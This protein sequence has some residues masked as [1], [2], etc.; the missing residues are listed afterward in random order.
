MKKSVLLLGLLLVLCS[1]Q[2]QAPRPTG[3]PLETLAQPQSQSS[4]PPPQPVL[5]PTP[6]KTAVTLAWEGQTLSGVY[7]AQGKDYLD[8]G[9]LLEA[10]GQEYLMLPGLSEHALQTGTQTYSTRQGGLFDGQRFFWPVEELSGIGVRSYR[11]DGELLVL[12]PS[13]CVPSPGVEVPVLMY[14]S[15]SDDCWGIRE[16]FVSPKEMEKQLAYMAQQGY[17]GLWFSQLDRA[18]EMEKPVILTFDDGYDDNYTQ[19]FPLLKKYNIRA[20]VFVVTNFVGQPHYLT[21]EQIL[22]MAQSGLVEFQSHTVYHPNLDE[23]S[24]DIQRIQL[25]QSKAWLARLLHRIPTVLC[26]PAGRTNATTLEL[27][28]EY[29]DFGLLMQAGGCYSTDDDPYKVS[30]YYVARHTSLAQFQRMIER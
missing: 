22:E 3:T 2:G 14:H 5:D 11:P 7:R 24:P 23:V 17:T 15:V 6:K 19:L 4:L 29:Y 28:R 13:P 10:M 1:C 20:T 18:N 27:A 8:L 16:L 26:Y 12:G 30:R 9:E 25:S 21:Q